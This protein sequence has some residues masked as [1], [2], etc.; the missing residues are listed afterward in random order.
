[1]SII[2]FSILSIIIFLFAKQAY[3]QDCHC[4]KP[5]FEIGFG[6][7]LGIP[8][9]TEYQVGLTGFDE[10]RTEAKFAY[11]FHLAIRTHPAK[12]QIGLELIQDLKR[13]NIYLP[14]YWPSMEESHWDNSYSSFRLGLGA[15]LRYHFGIFYVQGGLAHMEEFSNTSQVIIEEPGAPDHVFDEGYSPESGLLINASIGLKGNTSRFSTALGFG[16]DTSV[17]E[18]NHEEYAHYWKVRINIISLTLNYQFNR[19][20]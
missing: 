7:Q 2:R 19:I 17:N 6:P 16:Y 12:F 14:L 5:E 11:T 1:M 3:S 20:E 10:P 8:V 18:F 13:F 4:L 9:I 15:H